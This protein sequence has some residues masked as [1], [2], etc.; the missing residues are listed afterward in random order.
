MPAGWWLE[1]VLGPLLDRGMSRGG[2]RVKK[3]L[4]RGRSRD[5]GG[6][7]RGDHFLFYKFIERTTER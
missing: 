6:I 4:E 2:Y 1:L 3:S 5:G 7:G